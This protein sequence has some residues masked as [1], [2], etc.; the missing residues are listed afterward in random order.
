MD[1]PHYMNT[2]Y[3]LLTCT[4]IS[5]ALAVDN[6]FIYPYE[7]VNGGSMDLPYAN[8]HCTIT[9]TNHNSTGY[10]LF[11]C[12]DTN[13]F[14]CT[15]ND[16]HTC[17]QN[18]SCLP[19]VNNTSYAINSTS[20]NTLYDGQCTNGWSAIN[21]NYVQISFYTSE[22]ENE[23]CTLST[24]LQT[25]GTL[26]IATN[27]CVQQAD[28]SYLMM[29]CNGSTAQINL[30]ND[31]TCMQINDTLIHYSTTCEYYSNHGT[32]AMYSRLE[33]CYV[34]N[35]DQVRTIVPTTYPTQT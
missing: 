12:N 31:S 11:E 34:D 35:T 16:Y 30:Y 2:I 33:G 22:T 6:Y 13:S 10:Y 15:N 19:N 25:F 29:S 14:Y 17:Q 26:Y 21:A 27:I 4:V 8:G 7:D 9:T 20:L 5:I 24:D 1:K 32:D 3:I 23:T 18:E 28:A